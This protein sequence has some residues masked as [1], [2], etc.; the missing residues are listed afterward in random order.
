MTEH[1]MLLMVQKKMD[2]MQ[3]QINGLVKERDILRIELVVALNE[4]DTLEKQLESA[5]DQ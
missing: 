4:I 3:E 2:A 5:R 1:D